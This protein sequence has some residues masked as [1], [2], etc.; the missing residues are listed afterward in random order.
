MTISSASLI[1]YTNRC[2]E[3]ILRDQTSPSM[4]VAAA[5]VFLS[6]YG[7]ARQVRQKDYRPSLQV[8]ISR[9]FVS[10]Q[11]VRSTQGNIQQIDHNPNFNLISSRD[12]YEI[13]DLLLMSAMPCSIASKVT[14]IVEVWI[15]ARSW[16]DKYFRAWSYFENNVS[17]FHTNLLCKSELKVFLLVFSEF[18]SCNEYH[19]S[20][21]Y[22][23][24][25]C[26]VC[27]TKITQNYEKYYSGTKKYR[28]LI[29]GRGWI[30]FRGHEM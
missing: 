1:S 19:G 10:L 30:S 26:A 20:N 9:F 2:L 15:S 22:C 27:C 8:F 28:E 3:S 11:I 18:R 6:L 21:F 14:W 29:G 12:T 23:T 17:A 25:Y 7:D 4:C 13:H 5:L 24:S 16:V